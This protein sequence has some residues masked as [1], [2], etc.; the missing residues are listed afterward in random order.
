MQFE[1]VVY[2][3]DGDVCVITLNRPDALNALSL[4]LTRDLDSAIRQAINDKARAIVITP[5]GRAFC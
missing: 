4:K 2:E 1:T 5:N 3:R